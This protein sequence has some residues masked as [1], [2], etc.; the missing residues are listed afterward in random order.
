M[1]AGDGGSA[2]D[3]RAPLDL[4]QAAGTRSA[5]SGGA[6]NVAKGSESVIGGGISNVVDQMYSVIGGGYDN[7]VCF[8]FGL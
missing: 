3:L 4:A 1:R 5:V 8:V 2:H 6:Y 7:S